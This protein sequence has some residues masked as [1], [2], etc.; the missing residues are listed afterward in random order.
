MLAGKHAVLEAL[1]A[2][3][4]IVEIQFLRG[5]RKNL[6]VLL[7]LAEQKGIKIREVGTKELDLLYV[8]V[9]QGVVAKLSKFKYALLDDVVS[10]VL[11]RGAFFVVLDHL[12]DPHNFGAII[13]TAAVF[14][15]D[16]IIIP[17]DRSV[18]ITSTVL[19][20]ASGGCEYV[21]IIMVRNIAETIDKLKREGVVVYAADLQGESLFEFKFSGDLAIVFGAEGKGVSRLAKE[22]SNAL[23]TIPMFGESLSLNV[24]V[25]AGIIIAEIAKQKQRSSC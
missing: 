7:N 16:G 18:Q 12:T 5:T 6:G 9:H 23:L 21:P 24:S 1:S 15:V 14:G 4:E 3:R 2:G 11:G 17:R 10:E 25:A 8:G 19:K 22:R 13:R 20:V